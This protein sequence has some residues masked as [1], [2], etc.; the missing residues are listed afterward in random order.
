MSRK[1]VA[2]FSAS[3]TTAKV[4][5][6]LADSLDADLFE[7]KPKEP[8]TDSDLRWTNPLAR[9]NREKIRRKDV[10]LEN[11][12]ENLALY[13]TIFLGFPIWY[14]AA[15]NIIQ[16]FL[17]EHDFSGLKIAL[18]ATLGGSDINKCA[19]KLKP[20]LASESEIIGAKLFSP[21][22]SANNLYLW[23]ETL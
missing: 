8:Y 12:I 20:Y 21:N 2:Y 13:D 14:Y 5:K 18:F 7:I 3:G 10:P 6:R 9:S 4:A 17:K 19:A 1:L 11:H 23:T 15:P 22:V 16:T